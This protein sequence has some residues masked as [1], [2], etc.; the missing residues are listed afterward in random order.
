MDNIG[1]RAMEKENSGNYVYLV[2]K[3]GKETIS[4][5]YDWVNHLMAS[6]IRKK[7][8]Q[9]RVLVSDDILRH[10]I[11]DYFV[12]ID[13]LIEFQ[14]IESVHSSK[15]YAYLAYWILRHK[16]M[17]ITVSEGAA[18]LCF[19]NEEFACCLIR[20]YLFSEPENVA[21][22]EDKRECVDNFADTMLYYFQYRDY[23]AKSIELMI[24][25]FQAGCA[26]QYS[27]DRQ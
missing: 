4:S 1:D 10:V 12:D 14:E 27:A 23:S 13:R 8:Y 25:A 21:I 26:Y 9:E 7:G 16:P 11:V 22:L 19:V 2:K 5:R 15:I 20:S 3:I 24:L 18:G 17:Q 6:F